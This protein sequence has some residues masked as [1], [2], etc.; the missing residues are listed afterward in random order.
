MY[1]AVK[2]N[3]ATVCVVLTLHVHVHTCAIQAHVASTPPPP[4]VYH[5]SCG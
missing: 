5:L 3:L 1:S 4:H 2:T